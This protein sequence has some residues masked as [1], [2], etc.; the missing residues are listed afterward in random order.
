MVNYGNR[1]ASS[2]T[3]WEEIGKS[4][5]VAMTASIGVSLVIR[6]LIA[7]RVGNVKGA[8]GIIYNSISAFFAVST[9]GFLNAYL[10]RLKELD[11]GIDIYEPDHPEIIVGKSKA[12]AE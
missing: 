9:A 10:M 11:T 5:V 8:K 4:Y 3:N 1:N 7:L 2:K 12:A 6:K